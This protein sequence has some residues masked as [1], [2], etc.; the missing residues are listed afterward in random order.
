MSIIIFLLMLTLLVF[1]HELGHFLF[2]KK[3]GIR[4]DEF[5]IGFPPKI[6]SFTKGETKYSLNIVP[7][8]GYVKI[9]GENPDDESIAGPDKERSFVNK[10]KKVQAL[11]LFGGI[12][13]NILFAFVLFSASYMI[14]V[15]GL[16]QDERQTPRLYVTDIVKDSPAEKSG[17]IKGDMILS[18]KEGESVVSEITPDVVRKIVGAS[19]GKPVD[20]TILRNNESLQ[21]S[22]VPEKGVATNN[23]YAIGIQMVELS[24][25]KLGFFASIA[26]GAEM[27]M[28]VTKETVV[29]ILSFLKNVVTFNADFKSVSGPVGIAGLVGEASHFGFGYLISFAALIS[30]NLAV[31]NLIPFPALDGGRLLFVAIEAII[32]RPLNPKIANTVNAIGF[33]LLLTLMVFVTISDVKRLF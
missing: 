8:G 28:L 26:K 25:L 30:I 12:L 20:L 22:V 17:L 13:F 33:I 1:V 15:T 6:F 32:K 4:V 9:F 3:N 24:N 2:A 10:S 5:A 16:P 29:G 11:V 27:T 23:S 18:L 21:V 31:I 7:L 19:E 14:G